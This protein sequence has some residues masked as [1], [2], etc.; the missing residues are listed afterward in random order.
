MPIFFLVPSA[1]RVSEGGLFVSVAEEIEGMQPTSYVD[2]FEIGLK[3]ISLGISLSLGLC[4]AV[5]ILH[6]NHVSRKRRGAPYTL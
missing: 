3:M 1:L 2:S 5:F 4:F 6:P